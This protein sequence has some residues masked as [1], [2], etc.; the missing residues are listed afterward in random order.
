MEDGC[1]KR[2][3]TSSHKRESAILIGLKKL[4]KRERER[5]DFC[6]VTEDKGNQNF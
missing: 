4:N 6:E 1:D 3:R 5:I 2:K